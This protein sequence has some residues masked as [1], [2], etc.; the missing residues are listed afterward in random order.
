MS[1]WINSP[2]VYEIHA[3]AWLERIRRQAGDGRGVDFASIPQAELERLARLRIDGVWLMG[4]WMRSPLGRKIAIEHTGLQAEYEKA[5][6]G[7]TRQDVVGSPYAIYDYSVDPAL[8]GN[9]GL[10]IL[11]DRLRR[12][13]LLLILDFVPNHLAIDHSWVTEHPSRFVR[14]DESLLEAQPYNYFAHGS[15]GVFAYGRDPNFFGWTDTVQLDFRRA[16]TRQAMLSTLLSLSSCCDGIRCDMA[17]LVVRDIFVRTWGG[18]F[19]VPDEE[20]WPMAINQVK[21]Q[22]QGFL[23]FAETYWDMEWTLQNMGFDY[24][25][26]KRLY[27]RLV[28]GE[29][30]PVRDHMRA[31]L[32]FQRKLVRF[33]ENHDEARAAAVFGSRRH[34]TASVAALAAPGLRLIHDG[35]VEG[36]KLRLPVQLGRRQEEC[37]DEGLV[38]FY[39]K[40]LS[41][42]KHPIFHEGEWAVLTPNAAWEGNHSYF[43]FLAYRWTH[44][45]V[46]RV[47]VINLG[48][49][50]A[51][52]YL[53]LEVIGLHSCNWSLNDMLND[54]KYVRDGQELSS[55]GLYLD[56]PGYDYHIFDL[57]PV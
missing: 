57:S 46:F 18:S 33:V 10:R 14:G 11:R 27:D 45:G 24:V 48:P 25:Y 22:N 31:G 5:L 32:D 43:D 2:V 8:G 1:V 36:C 56:M 29:P 12:L 38:V 28:A 6:P 49:G 21:L 52:C 30:A 41:G 53:P 34:R 23:M 39:E 20:F 9:E 7:Y 19:D 55:H 15:G 16:E 50:R 26:D 47:V 3:W 54:V 44:R 13:G 4:V 42:L 17:M 37:V 40:L 35:Q 51:Q